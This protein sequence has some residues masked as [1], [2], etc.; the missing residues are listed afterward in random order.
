MKLACSSHSRDI[1]G[2][3]CQS[4]WER[5]SQKQVP[6]SNRQHGSWSVP[7]FLTDIPPMLGKNC[8]DLPVWH[9][10]KNISTVSWCKRK[11]VNYRWVQT[12]VTYNTKYLYTVMQVKS[13]PLWNNL[14]QALKEWE[15]QNT[16]R[17][18]NLEC[19]TR[20]DSIRS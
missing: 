13:K 3:K 6:T 1:I 16:D 11:N 9:I 15:N 8:H 18:S 5:G 17:R 7:L 14:K 12:A 2:L 19:G 20:Y 4:Q 10:G